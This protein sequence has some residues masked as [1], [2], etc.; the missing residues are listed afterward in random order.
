MPKIWADPVGVGQKPRIIPKTG[1][2]T[3][4]VRNVFSLTHFSGNLYIPNL[5]AWVRTEAEDRSQG[6]KLYTE[7]HKYLL[8]NSLFREPLYPPPYNMVR[9]EAKDHSRS[10]ITTHRMSE[11]SSPYLPSPG[12]FIISNLT[13]CLVPNSTNNIENTFSHDQAIV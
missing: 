1:N 13:T 2:Y 10:G 12:T 6:R 7:C 5:R 11:I 8:L 9:I 4:H 3:P